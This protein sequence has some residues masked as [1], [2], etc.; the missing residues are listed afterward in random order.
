VEAARAGE[1]GRGF[2]VVASEVRSL[3]G[4][5]ATA[6]KEIKGLIQDSV[7]KVEEGSKLVDES[8]KALEDIVNSV[9]RVTDIVSEIAAASQEQSSGIEQVGK[10]VM[11]MDQATQQ[12]AAL[13]E[14]AAAASQLIVDQASA[15][16]EL[17]AKYD[18]GEVVRAPAATPK[19]ASATP[20]PAERRG[21]KRPW[22]KSVKSGT[23]SAAD[24]SSAKAAPTRAA[25]TRMAAGNGAPEDAEW[26][27]F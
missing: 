22:T 11:Q 20:T 15:L 5:S 27:Q 16:N 10:A 6:A 9:K 24:A 23:S 7:V 19:R 2:A 21:S 25:A 18:V 13:V 4:R 1:Q 14:Q 12:N 26:K 17:I 3:A 8:G